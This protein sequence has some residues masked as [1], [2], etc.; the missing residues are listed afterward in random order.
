MISNLGNLN[1]YSYVTV[2][3]GGAGKLYVPVSPS[4]VIYAQFDHISGIAARQ[5][6]NGVSVSKL[7]ILNSLIENLSS[8]RSTPKAEVPAELSDRQADVLIKQ[9]QQQMA[10]TIQAAKETPYLMAG[11][12][13]Q[14]GALFSVTA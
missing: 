7:Q 6:Q 3:S 14:T 1:P 4:S 8:I 12:Q 9:Y 10:Q 11:V 5:G 2:V 13:P